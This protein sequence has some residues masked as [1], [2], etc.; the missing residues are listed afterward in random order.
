MA[1]DMVDEA[2]EGG[3][4]APVT[5]AMRKGDLVE[6]VVAVSGVKKQTVKP[7]VEA[8]LAELGAA[9]HRGDALVLSPLGRLTVSRSR[10]AGGR[11]VMLKLRRP[12]DAR[13]GA[14]GADPAGDTT[15]D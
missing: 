5:R 2:G 7:V 10:G 4:A 3:T 13:D 9:L 11:V 6:A 15:E 1:D 14:A 12:R 8:V